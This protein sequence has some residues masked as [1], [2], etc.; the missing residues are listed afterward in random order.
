MT[1]E[2]LQTL[3]PYLDAAN[4]DLKFFRDSSYKKICAA[5]LF[6]VLESIKLMYKLGI[7]VE[8]TTLIVPG[9][10]DS[11]EELKEIA[12]FIASVD[13]N[14]PWHVSRFH[15]DYKFNK[16]EATPE[17]SLKKACEIGK[18]SGLNFI[19]AGNIIGWGNDTYCQECGKL[20]V[21]REVFN[22]LENDIKRGKCA[23]CQAVIPGV[24]A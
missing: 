10:N 11:E 19:Y 9:E 4:V 5:S 7:W 21:K 20:L 17:A 22:I 24:F 8:V 12:G 15:P 1:A 2:A 16:A 23:F 13:R 3:Q 18:D 14:M 6:P